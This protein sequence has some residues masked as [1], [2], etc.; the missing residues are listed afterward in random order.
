MEKK[1]VTLT[2][3]KVPNYLRNKVI[4]ISANRKKQKEPRASISEVYIEA[5]EAGLKKLE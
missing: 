4:D 2:S 3:L 5:L 1:V